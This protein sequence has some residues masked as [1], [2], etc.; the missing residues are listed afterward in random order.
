MKRYTIFISIVAAMAML[1]GTLIGC[2]TY[3]EAAGLGG[4]LGA[5]TG[6]II[7]NQSGHAIEG[8]LIGGAL[9]GIAGLIAHD[10]KAKKQRDAAA[11]AAAYNYQPAEGLKLISEDQSVAPVRVAPGTEIETTFT[12]TVLGSGGGVEVKETRMI[13]Q[14]ERVISTF[15]SSSFMRDDGTWYSVQKIRLPNS[16]PMGQYAVVTK[17]RTANGSEVA[18]FPSAFTVSQ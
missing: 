3:G 8:A 13:L 5:G 18:S 6:A 17:V 15:N 1:A 12:Y 4:L 16:M 11:A 2:Q 10:I 14:Q 7:G 9:G